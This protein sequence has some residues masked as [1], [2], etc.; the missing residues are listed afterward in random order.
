MPYTPTNNPYAVGDPYMY[1][2]KWI[3]DKIKEYA[4]Y[5]GKITNLSNEI[6]ELKTYVDNFIDNLDIQAEVNAKIDDLMN[7]GAFDNILSALIYQKRANITR[8]GRFLDA[9]IKNNT[10]RILANQ[11]CCYYN[12]LFYCCGNLASDD[13]VQSITVWNSNGVMLNSNTYSE[14]GHANDITYLNGKLYI[15]TGSQIGIVDATTLTFEGYISTSFATCRAVSGDEEKIYIIGTIAGSIFGIETF[16]PATSERNVL[17]NNLI[18][19]GTVPQGSCYYNGY[20]Y[21]MFNRPNILQKIN[22]TTG[23]TEQLYN[24][25]SNDGYFWTGEMETP[26]IVNNNLCI[27]CAF[28]TAY[29]AMTAS[30]GQIFQTDIISKLSIENYGDYMINVDPVSITVN[31]NATQQFNPTTEFTVADETNIIVP[32]TIIRLSNV[33]SGY[34]EVCRGETKSL[35]RTAGT[36]KLSTIRC[37]GSTLKTDLVSADVLITEGSILDILFGTFDSASLRFSHVI[38]RNATFTTFSNLERTILQLNACTV[39]NATTGST[40]SNAFTYNAGVPASTDAGNKAAFNTIKNAIATVSG[41][42]YMTLEIG[43]VSSNIYYAFAT[44]VQYSIFSSGITITNGNNS[45][46]F[47]DTNGLRL[48]VNGVA[49]TINQ[50][51]YINCTC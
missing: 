39:S 21:H 36:I 31:G 42:K 44:R 7:S 19:A 45:I 43:V 48:T 23:E 29:N 49:Q 3:V 11:S 15:A 5:A 50:T 22:V 14:L 18:N 9:Y 33:L 4:N 12:N 47:D 10:T 1:D 16:D 25:P 35:I 40:S 20:I 27:Y 46:T 13:S 38:A 26:L 41:S 28:A 17:F 37:Y 51:V 34:I 2:L 32:T 8:L 30:I 6:D 24:I